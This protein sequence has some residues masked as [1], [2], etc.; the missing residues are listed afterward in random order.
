MHHH[1]ETRVALRELTENLEH[2]LKLEPTTHPNFMLWREIGTDRYPNFHV[3][4]V[5]DTKPEFKGDRALFVGVEGHGPII[6]HRSY[7]MNTGQIDQLPTI[8][9]LMAKFWAEGGKRAVLYDQLS[10]ETVD[11]IF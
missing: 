6:W 9:D 11:R 4:G 1:K 3:H 2:T 5:L 10:Q 8:E 7:Q